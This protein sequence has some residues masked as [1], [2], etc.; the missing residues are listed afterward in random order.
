[1]RIFRLIPSLSLMIIMACSS[2]QKDPVLL[3][4]NGFLRI[5]PESEELFRVLI[6]SDGYHLS[7]MKSL[8]TIRRLNDADGDQRICE[9]LRKLDKI[10]EKRDGVI[11]VWLFPDSGQLMKV[12]PKVLTYLMEIDNLIVED[13]KRWN[14]DFPEEVVEPAFFD[15]KY[16]IIL[17]KRQSDEEIMMEVRE[18]IREKRDR[19]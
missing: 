3:Q 15:I 16:R 11:T 19:R 5:D 8:S 7:Q 6:S 4:N 2:A 9:E 13:V 12:R 18:R 1:M 14:F 17:R 10:D